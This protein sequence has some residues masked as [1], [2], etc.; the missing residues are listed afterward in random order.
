VT[1]QEFK[2]HIL[3]K[4]GSWVSI[5]TNKSLSGNDEHTTREYLPLWAGLE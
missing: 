5:N 1:K 2:F 4:G 3:K